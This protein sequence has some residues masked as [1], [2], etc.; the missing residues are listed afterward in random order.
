MEPSRPMVLCDPVTAARG[1]FATLDGRTKQRT[2]IT[3]TKTKSYR[4]APRIGVVCSMSDSRSREQAVSSGGARMAA[5][6]RSAMSTRGMSRR[7]GHASLSGSGVYR[8]RSCPL[9]TSWRFRTAARRRRKPQRAGPLDAAG[10]FRR[11]RH[12]SFEGDSR[13]LASSRTACRNHGIGCGTRCVAIAPLSGSFETRGFFRT[14]VSG[15]ALLGI[16]VTRSVRGE[17]PEC[18]TSHGSGFRHRCV[19]PRRFAG[20]SNLV[21]LVGVSS[22]RGSFDGPSN[23]QMEPSRPMVLCDPVTAARGSFATLYG[24]KTKDFGSVFHPGK[25]RLL[26]VHRGVVLLRDP[27]VARGRGARFG[28]VISVAATSKEKEHLAAAAIELIWVTS[29]SSS[30]GRALSGSGARPCVVEHRRFLHRSNV[31]GGVVA[32]GRVEGCADGQ[33]SGVVRLHR[34][35]AALGVVRSAGAI[36]RV[37]IWRGLIRGAV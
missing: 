9:R 11:L 21:A 25:L 33:H 31:R 37:S 34:C 24:Q 23:T 20:D 14:F 3:Q 12:H 29:A 26:G 16:R 36:A 2:R 6:L 22:S 5:F 10:L 4:A 17:R 7:R 13:R 19:A 18:F 28:V 30:N 8:S 15:Q 32:G 27:L 35:G 1:S